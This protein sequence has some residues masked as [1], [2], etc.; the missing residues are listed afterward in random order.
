[1]KKLYKAVAT[2]NT[3][4]VA[5]ESDNL[6]YLAGKFC[7]EERNNLLPSVTYEEVKSLDDLPPGWSGGEYLW[8]EVESE[9]SV[10]DWFGRPEAKI[11]E[12]EKEIERLKQELLLRDLREVKS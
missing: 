10:R 5:E 3:M 8:G 1:M 12:L 6:L 2:I 11:H 7:D 4:F 9:V